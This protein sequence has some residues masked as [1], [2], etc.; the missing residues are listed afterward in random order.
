MKINSYCCGILL[1]LLALLVEACS[2]VCSANFVDPVPTLW[3]SLLILCVPG[4]HFHWTHR[5]R[6]GPLMGCWGGFALAICAVYSVLLLPLTPLASLALP[7]FGFG[8]LAF[9]PHLAFQATLRTV[10]FDA[11]TRAGVYLGIL[12]LLGANLPIVWTRHWI[13]SE[14]LFSLRYFGN[15]KLLLGAC[16]HNYVAAPDISRLWDRDEIPYLQADRVFRGVYGC[17]PHDE[18]TQPLALASHY[19]YGDARAGVFHPDDIRMTPE[20]PLAAL[21]FVGGLL[22]MRRRRR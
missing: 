1:P 9:S 12:A 19:M 17:A 14:D 5:Q 4:F 11:G 21:F 3:H 15:R 6:R 10:V 7:W 18:S 13:A 20:P 2:G 8:L 22:A 16:V